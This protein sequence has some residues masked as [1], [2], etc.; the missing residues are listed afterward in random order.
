MIP[1]VLDASFYIFAG[2]LA[3]LAALVLLSTFTDMTRK[4]RG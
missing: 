4:K 2:S 3:V 1:D